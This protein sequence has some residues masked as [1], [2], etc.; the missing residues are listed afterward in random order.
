MERY[1]HIDRLKDIVKETKK[2][3]QD[4]A[5]ELARKIV[6]TKA[7]GGFPCSQVK[8][9][10]G[11]NSEHK[12]M[13]ENTYAEAAEKVKNW[14]NRI[15]VG[16]VVRITDCYGYGLVLKMHDGHVTGITDGGNAFYRKNENVFKTGRTLPVEDWLKQIGGEE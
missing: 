3:G 2:A 6:L 16:D 8:E 5:W 10:F 15:K 11:N 1:V 7:H 4:E 12:I 9:M 14:E 13:L